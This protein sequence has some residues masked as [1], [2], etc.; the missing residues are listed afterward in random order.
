M[1]IHQTKL[2]MSMPHATGTFTPHSPIPT[3][4]RFVIASSISWNSANEIAKPKNHASDVFRFKTI[5][6]ILSVTDANVSPGSMTGVVECIGPSMYGFCGSL[7]ATV[8][9]NFRI[10][11]LHVRQVSRARMRVQL[12]QQRVIAFARFQLVYAAIWSVDIAEDDHVSRANCLAGGDD[13][14]VTHFPPP[15]DLCLNLRVL[16]ALH[17][18]GALLHYAAAAH[19]HFRIALQLI[20]RL[21]PVLIQEEVKATHFVRAVVGTVLRAHATVVDHVVQAFR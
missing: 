18:V 16:N 19:A 10:R 20:K 11:V 7:S 9:S 4:T 1:P 6:L 5:E 8:F 21:I 12:F 15:F 17:A 3:N 13:L 14:A 2:R